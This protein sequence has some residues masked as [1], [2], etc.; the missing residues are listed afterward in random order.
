MSTEI[1][2]SPWIPLLQLHLFPMF[3]KEQDAGYFV[4]MIIQKYLI[5]PIT[6]KKSSLTDLQHNLETVKRHLVDPRQTAL[7]VAETLYLI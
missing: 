1:D 4:F 5:F 2:I 3:T 6:N 7:N